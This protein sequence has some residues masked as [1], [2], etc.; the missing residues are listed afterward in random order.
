[1]PRADPYVGYVYPAGGQ[2]GTTFRVKFGG[3]GVE[4]V[5]DIVV[6]G[7]GVSGKVLQHYWPLG[8]TGTRFLNGQLDWFKSRVPKD[9]WD[10]LTQ[11][12]SGSNSQM[13][14]MA[15]EMSDS[16]NS[17][18]GSSGASLDAS[19]LGID[20]TIVSLVKQ[21]RARMAEYV[22]YAANPS[23]TNLVFAEVTIAADAP[24]GQT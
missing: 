14:M 12:T 5:H 19:K 7:K 24:P 10:K 16:M 20:P 15:Q 13:A 6:S 2:T 8:V 1:M 9:K 17:P 18:G 21:I 4:G 23:I 3:Q 22:L 11:A